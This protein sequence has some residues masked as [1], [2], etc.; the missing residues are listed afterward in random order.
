[1]KN[2]PLTDI[3]RAEAAALKAIYT[4]KK[5]S[6]KLT[7]QKIAT[8]LGDDESGQSL[9]SNYLNGFCPLNLKAALVFSRM[10]KVPVRDFSP[11]LADEIESNNVSCELKETL[12]RRI[13]AMSENAVKAVLSY[14]DF[15]EGNNQ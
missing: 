6:L 1:M 2:R 15:I 5:E 11:R 3:E 8:E 14:L 12:K 4:A 13:D 9:A 7:Q 10:L